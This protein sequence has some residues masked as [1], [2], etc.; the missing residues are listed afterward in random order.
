MPS[1]KSVTLIP[2]TGGASSPSDRIQILSQPRRSSTGTARSVHSVPEINT[3]PVSQSAHW[4]PQHAY[5]SNMPSPHIDQPTANWSTHHSAHQPVSLPV[6]DPSMHAVD[7]GNLSYPSPYGM[8][9]NSRAMSYP[10]ESAPLVTSQP[11]QMG[12]YNTPTSNPSPHPS[13]YQRH[14]S[15]PMNAPPPSGH[16]SHP[17]PYA[18]SGHQGYVPQTSHPSDMHLMASTQHPQ[19]QMMGEQGQM[20]YHLP[21]SM[22]VE[23]S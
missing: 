14:V 16:P 11:M 4:T 8:D 18:S 17:N 12:G 2:T 6:Q 20:M 7:S 10:L 5:H 21:P 19:P 3:A 23:H 13:D 22:K 15:V 1:S 9:S